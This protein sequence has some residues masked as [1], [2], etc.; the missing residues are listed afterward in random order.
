LVDLQLIDLAIALYPAYRV[1]YNADKY[2][3]Q[4]AQ[5]NGAKYIEG[6]L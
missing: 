3:L 1:C 6:L 2:Y 4:I 5:S